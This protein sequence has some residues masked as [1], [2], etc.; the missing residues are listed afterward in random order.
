[1]EQDSRQFNA[2]TRPIC[3]NGAEPVPASQFP[4]LL[5]AKAPERLCV[6]S[7]VGVSSTAKPE[8][9][10]RAPIRFSMRVASH[11]S[12]DD[13]HADQDMGAAF[14]I[15]CIKSSASLVLSVL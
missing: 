2:A 6:T 1:M 13:M 4:K 5:S 15:L 11:P 3:K 12:A 8:W 7:E 14:D 9:A 10:C